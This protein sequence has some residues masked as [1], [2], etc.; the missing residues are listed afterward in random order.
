MA[1]PAS[2]ETSPR[3]AAKMSLQAVEEW[4]EGTIVGR[5]GHK[6]MSQDHLMSGIYRNLSIVALHEPISCRQDPAVGIGEVALRPVWR[7]A[8]LSPQGSPLPAHA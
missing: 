8:V 4:H 3:L 6:P 5:G 7:A 1:K 2:P